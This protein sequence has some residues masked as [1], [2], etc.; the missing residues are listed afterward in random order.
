MVKLSFISSSI[1]LLVGCVSALPTLDSFLPEAGLA[2]LYESPDA[3][4]ISDSYIVVLKDHVSA[5]KAREHC[6][7]VRDLHKRD[8][9]SDY[10]DPDMAAGIK[11]TYDT[12]GLRGYAGKFSQETLHRIRSSPEVSLH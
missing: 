6:H 5:D 7:W 8:A 10:L 11:H 9:L 4:P 1:L 12:P 3:E 2:P